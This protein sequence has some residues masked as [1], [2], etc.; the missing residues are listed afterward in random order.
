MWAGLACLAVK[1]CKHAG[2]DW[3]AFWLRSV[4][5]ITTSV[6]PESGRIVYAGSDFPHPILS[7]SSKEDPDHVVQNLP[8]SD[9]GGLGRFWP[10][11]S[12]PEASRCDCYYYWLLFFLYRYSLLSGRLTALMSH[13]ILNERLYSFMVRCLISTQVVYWQRYL[14]GA[15]WIWCRVGARSVYTVQPCTSLPCHFV[16]LCTVIVCLAVFTWS[17][18]NEEVEEI[19]TK[20]FKERFL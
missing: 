7:R 3:E 8:R 17:P 16:V 20:T 15:I 19:Q 13:V 12:G 18:Q 6:Q 10:N 2:S 11:G 4:M 9:L 1:P 5:A 14:A